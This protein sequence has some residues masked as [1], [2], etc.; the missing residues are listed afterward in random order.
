MD[1]FSA[2][3]ETI[4]PVQSHSRL[5]FDDMRRRR[6][7]GDFISQNVVLLTAESH[8]DSKPRVGLFEIFFSPT[9][10]MR[11]PPAYAIC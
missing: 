5:F 2:T 11:L 9:K 6:T 7:P 4:F 8:L 3:N 1:N 10:P